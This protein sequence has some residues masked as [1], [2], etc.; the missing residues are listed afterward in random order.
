MAI[1]DI[2][3]KVFGGN[4][5]EGLSKLVSNFKL[6]PE[7]KAELEA[8]FETHRF[9]IAKLEAEY[10]SKL[11]DHEAKIVESVNATMREEAKS[12]HWLQWSWRPLVGITFCA[13]IVNNYILLPYLRSK[14]L[15][16]IE[17]PA[18]IWDSMLVV[19][20]VAAGTRGWQKAMEAKNG[21][22]GANDKK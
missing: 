8:L 20:G 13:V 9:E 16:P 15:A 17:I 10:E 12:E 4:L 14:G 11:L 7:K 18:G 5:L 1:S 3:T 2:F 22:G 21:N 6:S 19:L